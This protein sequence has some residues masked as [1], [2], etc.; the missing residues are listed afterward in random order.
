MFAM[1]RRVA[2]LGMLCCLAVPALSNAASA[3]KKV[4]VPNFSMETFCTKAVKALNGDAALV[5]TCLEA[6]K[7]SLKELEGMQTT[8][9]AFSSCTTMSQNFGGS[10]EMLKKCLLQQAVI[11]GQ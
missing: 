5:Q 2:L 11:I 1:S 6:E 10:Y 7:Q 3:G 9:Q 8:E 4:S